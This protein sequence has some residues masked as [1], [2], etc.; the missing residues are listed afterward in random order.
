MLAQAPARAPE[1]ASLNAAAQRRVPRGSG[2]SRRRP[3]ACPVVTGTPRDA[4]L[5]GATRGHPRSRAVP[6]LTIPLINWDPP[7]HAQSSSCRSR[8][9]HPKT[10]VTAT[11]TRGD[12]KPKHKRRGD[13]GSRPSD[14][15][16]RD[17]GWWH[18]LDDS[19]RARGD[20]KP[21]GGREDAVTRCQNKLIFTW[22]QGVPEIVASGSGNYANH[23]VCW[24]GGNLLGGGI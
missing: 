22:F 7:S 1:Q 11:K 12:P 15:T 16:T 9:G 10:V 20:G 17:G 18:L 5:A 8:S 6:R 2:G 14:D 19:R 24:H 13:G 4:L 21:S 3:D 23:G